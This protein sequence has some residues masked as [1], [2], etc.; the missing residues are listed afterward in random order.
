MYR[1][2]K[3]VP[4]ALIPN[5]VSLPQLLPLVVPYKVFADKLS[6]ALGLA[7][8]PSKLCR[9][10]NPIPLVSTAN[11]VPLPKLL[12][13]FAVPYKVSFEKVRLPKG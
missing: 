4:S 1:G 9:F 7:S 6:P 2:V 8:S 10:V 5:T 12:P 3:P 11:M 13:Q